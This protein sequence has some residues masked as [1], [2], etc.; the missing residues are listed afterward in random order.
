MYKNKYKIF[1]LIISL[2]SIFLLIA[3]YYNN[4][5]TTNYKWS[6]ELNQEEIKKIKNSLKNNSDIKD[7]KL[8]NF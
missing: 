7:L 6:V 2:I 1:L 3:Y 4:S 8:N 5:K